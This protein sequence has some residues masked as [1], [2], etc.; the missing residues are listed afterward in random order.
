[1]RQI[2]EF[3][4][5]DIPLRQQRPSPSFQGPSHLPFLHAKP[6]NPFQPTIDPF[7]VSRTPAR[8]DCPPA[9]RVRASAPPTPPVIPVI[10]YMLSF[11][12]RVTGLPTSI[13]V[14]R[15]RGRDLCALGSRRSR[16]DAR[17]H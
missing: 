8:T 3:P 10:A 14:S 2:L 4:W 5:K 17:R 12:R 7:P 15:A 13:S 16:A 9:K 6:R 1:M 11:N